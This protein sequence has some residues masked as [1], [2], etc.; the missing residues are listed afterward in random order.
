MQGAVFYPRIHKKN[1]ETLHRI[2]VIKSAGHGGIL[3]ALLIAKR[4]KPAFA[5]IQDL[6]DFIDNLQASWASHPK[7]GL[8]YSSR[9]FQSKQRGRN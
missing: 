6:T 9:M 8:Q 2:L 4:K 1:A 5:R 7:V 3:L